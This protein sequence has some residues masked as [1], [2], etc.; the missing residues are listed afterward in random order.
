MKTILVIVA[1]GMKNCNTD[2]LADA[3]I[4]GASEAGHSV[5]KMFLGDKVINGCTGCNACRWGKPCVQKD[6]MQDI[7]PLYVKSDMV[8]LASPLY[9]WTI[10]ARL[11]AFLERL[12]AVAEEDDNPPKG[13]YEK[14]AEKDCA[15][16]MTAADDLFWTF[17]QAVSYYR[18]NCVNYLGWRDKGMVLAGGCGGSPT[19]RCIEET[20][21]L[22]EAY[23]FGKSV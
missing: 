17:E 13:R 15:L 3:F 6:A 9:F 10:S 23:G 20:G 8:V 12:Y 14:H 4:K 18:F 5:T 7:Y 11:K 21:H 1:S 19:K 2:K 16:L 22:D